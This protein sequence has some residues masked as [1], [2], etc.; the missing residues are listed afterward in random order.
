MQITKDASEG[1][2]RECGR[3]V[4]RGR[5]LRERKSDLGRGRIGKITK[6]RVFYMFF[7]PALRIL[8]EDVNVMQQRYMSNPFL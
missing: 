4:K 5:P 8:V 7:E 1:Y 6:K 3:Q 2:E